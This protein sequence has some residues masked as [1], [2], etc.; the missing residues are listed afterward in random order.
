MVRRSLKQRL[1][2]CA[3]EAIEWTVNSTYVMGVLCL[4]A[5]VYM[6]V[7][8][9]VCGFLG[10]KDRMSGSGD[11]KQR[12]PHDGRG[13]GKGIF[14]D[15]SVAFICDGN[16]RYMRKLGVED[17][18]TR[19]QGIRKIH[20]LIE[21]GCSNR[22][23]EVSFFCFALKNFQ[24][25]KNE[26]DGLMEIVKHRNHGVGET[27][28]RPRFKVYGRL[29]LLEEEVRN[30]F[31][32]IERETEANRDITVNIFFAYSAEDEISRGISFDSSVDLLIRTGHVRRLSDFMLRQV[33]R[34]T[35]VFFA[36]VLWPEFTATHLYLILLKHH[37]ENRY[38]LN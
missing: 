3:V 29:D 32:R 25:K 2:V 11:S 7:S 13:S 27:R 33:S 22:F 38:L 21:L 34:G 24:R 35:A 16:R 9:S 12:G 15:M 20:E 30:E 18:F 5:R 6:G 36:D 19:E 37:L 14:R 31:V 28:L 4:V 8:R 17:D 26:V 1:V 10:I 23:R